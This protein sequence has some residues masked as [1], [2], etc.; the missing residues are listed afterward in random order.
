MADVQE[1]LAFVQKVPATGGGSLYE[2]LT[3]LVVK[4]RERGCSCAR[5][6]LVQ[7]GCGPRRGARRSPAALALVRCLLHRVRVLR[8]FCSPQ[9]S[10]PAP[11]ASPGPRR[12]PH[13]RR[14][15]PRDRAACEEVGAGAARRRARRGARGA[16]HQMHCLHN[17]L[18]ARSLIQPAR[19]CCCLH[20]RVS[21]P[22]ADWPCACAATLPPQSAADAAKTVALAGL[23]G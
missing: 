2:Q 1:A 20:Q 22:R 13:R 6:G 14:R 3:K 4:V 5:A 8:A 15:C 19:R 12:A 10:A 16:Q 17:A 23:Y 9:T 7:A 21:S 18:P 11:A